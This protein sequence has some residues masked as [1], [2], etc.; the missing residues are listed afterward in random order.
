MM[1]GLVEQLVEAV[2]QLPPSDFRRFE[3][4]WEQVRRSREKED[5]ERLRAAANY[6]LPQTKQERLEELLY[7]GNAGTLTPKEQNEL[8][9]L[10]EFLDRKNL[11][12][13]RALHRLSQ[14]EKAGKANGRRGKA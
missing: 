5:I 8:N 9:R 4:A 14:L 1:A 13:A 2:K 10:L 11:E 3:R 6:R 12:K 7:K